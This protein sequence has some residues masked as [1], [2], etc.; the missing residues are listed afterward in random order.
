MAIYKLPCYFIQSSSSFLTQER[1]THY[2]QNLHK[3][4][5]GCF[6]RPEVRGWHVFL[7][8]YLV[9]I[10]ILCLLQKYGK[11][12]VKLIVLVTAFSYLI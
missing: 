2:G 5:I 8:I 4:P 10:T 3:A 12:P 11:N 7:A 1:Q 6:G 9:E